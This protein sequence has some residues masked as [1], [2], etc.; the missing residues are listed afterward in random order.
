MSPKGKSTNRDAATSKLTIAEASR[1]LEWITAFG[2][3]N[4]VTFKEA[5]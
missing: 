4:G 5:A 3:Q 2:T 1:F